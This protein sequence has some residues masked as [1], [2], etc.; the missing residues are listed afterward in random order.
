MSKFIIH[1][2][3]DVLDLNA[4]DCV[5][6]VIKLGKISADGKS[7]CYVTT[8]KTDIHVVTRGTQ[9]NGTTTFHVY[10]PTHNKSGTLTGEKND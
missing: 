6:E 5:A 10:K 4:A 3:D 8:F 2:A 9:K 1:V 7:Y